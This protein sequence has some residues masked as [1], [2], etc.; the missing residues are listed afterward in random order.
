MDDD[1][2]RGQIDP[3]SPPDHTRRMRKDNTAECIR[4]KAKQTLWLPV[5]HNGVQLW[6][7][8]A[9]VDTSQD[10]K[11]TYLP[12]A[13]DAQAGQSIAEL[14]TKDA[15]KFA[16]GHAD[17]HWKSPCRHRPSTRHQPLHVGKLFCCPSK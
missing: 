2:G 13:Q 3:S 17:G 10:R 8:P 14:G 9:P 5:A 16:F 6:G 11:V 15:G 1:R 12:S 7:I 4:A